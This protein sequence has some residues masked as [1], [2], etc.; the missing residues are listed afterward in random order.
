MDPET[1]V[2]TFKAEPDTRRRWP[3]P[4]SEVRLRLRAGQSFELE[5][6]CWRRGTEDEELQ[7]HLCA[8]AWFAPLAY[9]DPEAAQLRVTG[10]LRPQQQ[11]TK[12]VVQTVEELRNGARR[13]P[14]TE[15]DMYAV[16][17]PS[18]LNAVEAHWEGDTRLNVTLDRSTKW[19]VGFYK[20]SGNGW[21]S[22]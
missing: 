14:I 10:R 17:G 16:C 21:E 13:P 4:C 11:C 15:D 3:P 18:L 12:L 6:R 22:D 9:G 1:V 19:S 7:R 8:E 20:D 2:A 5:A